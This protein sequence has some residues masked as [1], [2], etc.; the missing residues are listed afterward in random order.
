MFWLFICLILG[1]IIFCI[2]RFVLHKYLS[3][4]NTL[5]FGFSLAVASLFWTFS[6][7]YVNSLPSDYVEVNRV[8]IYSI[9]NNNDIEGSFALGCGSIN[10]QMYFYYYISTD[11]GYS[12]EKIRSDGV[13]FVEDNDCIDYGYISFIEKQL[14]NE[15]NFFG[16][17]KWVPNPEPLTVIHLPKNSVKIDFNVSL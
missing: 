2:F 9:N 10:S 12:I 1:V 14:I 16:F 7:A 13:I 4:S 5:Y 6:L 15:D 8:N 11:Y 3:L 17:G